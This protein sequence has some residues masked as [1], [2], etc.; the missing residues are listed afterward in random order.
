MTRIYVH[1][2]NGESIDLYNLLTVKIP[3]SDKLRTYDPDQFSDLI[4][5]KK[6]F[7]TFVCV[8]RKISLFAED[9]LDV[10][11]VF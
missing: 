8:N 11:S 7:I 6:M 1:L 5:Q 4:L 3:Y 2:K 9:I 10:E